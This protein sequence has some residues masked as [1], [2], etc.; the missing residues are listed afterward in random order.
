MRSLLLVVFFNIAV[1]DCVIFSAAISDIKSFLGYVDRYVEQAVA[2]IEGEQTTLKARTDAVKSKMRL[3]LGQHGISEEGANRFLAKLKTPKHIQVLL[4]GKAEEEVEEL[5]LDM[6]T[7]EAFSR[8]RRY[9]MV[10]QDH[11]KAHAKLASILKEIKSEDI[12]GFAA[13]YKVSSELTLMLAR[14]KSHFETKK[15]L[16][17]QCR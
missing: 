11:L 17:G 3:L 12:P 1:F 16:K 5:P 13:S 8:L 4:D 6:S 10:L 14:L 2:H 15:R 7:P 9:M